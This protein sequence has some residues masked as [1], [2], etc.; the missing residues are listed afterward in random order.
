MGLGAL[1]EA[2]D[3]LATDDVMTLA[4]ADTL[5]ELHR[6]LA[7]L[8][9]VTTR[10]TAAFD[11]SGAWRDDGANNCGQWLITRCQLPDAV[12]KARV[13]LGRELRTLPVAEEAW[14]RGELT[15]AHV[16]MLARSR[17]PTTAHLMA[18]DEALL[19]SEAKGRRFSHFCRLVGYWRLR[20][21]AEGAEDEAR[22]DREDRSFHLSETFRG[23]W[24]GDLKLDPIG[25]TVVA[26]ELRRRTEALFEAEWAEAKARLGRDP[27]AGELGRTAAQRRADALVEMAVRSGTAPADGRRPEPLFTVLV[28]YETFDAM[29]CEL[30]NGLVVTPGSLVDWLDKAW[31]ERVVFGGRSRVIDVGVAQRLFGGATRRAVQVRD[32]ECFHDYCDVPAEQCQVDH[33]HP[34]SEGGPTVQDNGRVACGFHNRQAYRDREDD[35]PP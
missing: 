12:A 10:A 26:N 18:R 32:R 13:R 2:I 24:V 25:G 17:R 31:V 4:D 1:I 28:D 19:V 21:D 30:A 35:E 27:V 29:V 3:G 15:G 22:R 34:A 7:R 11:A 23:T 6:Q 20:A 5:V 14:L 16:G 9:A 33:V 8:E